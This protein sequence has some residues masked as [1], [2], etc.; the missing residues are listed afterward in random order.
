[1][2]DEL[3]T[4]FRKIY[5]EKR[6]DINYAG[7]YGKEGKVFGSICITFV[8][9]GTMLL[10][11]GILTEFRECAIEHIGAVMQLLGVCGILSL[12]CY[13]KH[14]Y[15]NINMERYKKKIFILREELY[16]RY[17][18]GTDDQVKQLS[19]QFERRRIKQKEFEDKL[20]KAPY[21]IMAVFVS[22]FI[23]ILAELEKL[24][25]SFFDWVDLGVAV[26]VSLLLIRAVLYVYQTC[27]SPI[28]DYEQMI[29]D[30][31]YSTI[32]KPDSIR[33]KVKKVS[34]S[35]VDGKA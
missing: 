12:N 26:I 14:K 8:S 13:Y 33:R 16:S 21:T 10:I 2:E 6:C 32:I 27:F 30:L 20:A 5:R 3:I 25:M 34:C 4:Q 1:M 24:S 31:Q 11:F 22:T 29:R 9:L 35:V 15:A 17:G 28:A 18:I 7:T 19:E 23:G